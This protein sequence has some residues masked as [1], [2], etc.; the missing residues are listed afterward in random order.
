MMMMINFHGNDKWSH[1]DPPQ[2]TSPIYL[3][4]IGNVA[5]ITITIIIY[6]APCMEYHNCCESL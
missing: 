1:F 6:Y 2:P 4:W 3:L 5:V